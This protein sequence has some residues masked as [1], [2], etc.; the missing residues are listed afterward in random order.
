[1]VFRRRGSFLRGRE[2][3]GHSQPQAPKGMAVQSPEGNPHQG[4][5]LMQRGLHI[6]SGRWRTRPCSRLTMPRQSWRL[7]RMAQADETIRPS[8]KA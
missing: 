2:F 8:C 3:E 4:C 6:A 1:V 5:M 7:T